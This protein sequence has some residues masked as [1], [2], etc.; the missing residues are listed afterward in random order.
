MATFPARSRLRTL[1]ITARAIVSAATALFV[2]FGPAWAIDGLVDRANR[3]E[4]RGHYEALQ[5]TLVQ[6]AQRAEAM[7]AIVAAIPQVAEAMQRGDRA[8]LAAMCGTAFTGLKT[9]YGIEQFQF[10]LPPATSFLRVNQ[11]EKFGDDLSAFRQTVVQANA[12]R[13]PVLGL[14]REVTGLGNRGVVPFAQAGRHPACRA[15]RIPVRSRPAPIV[16]ISPS[17]AGAPFHR[18]APPRLHGTMIA[19]RPSGGVTKAMRACR[20]FAARNDIRASTTRIMR[21]Q[22]GTPPGATRATSAVSFRAAGNTRKPCSGMRCIS[23]LS[24]WLSLVS[25]LRWTPRTA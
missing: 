24:R 5:A 18:G 10:H 4:L 7:A 22:Q 17:C 20:S 8:A 1:I 23:W 15:A 25:R 19:T 2:V 9:G 16:T 12:P 13:Q 6:E 14:E 11:P 21:A 3:R